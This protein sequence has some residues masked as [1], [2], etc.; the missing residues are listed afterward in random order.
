MNIT[1]DR[2]ILKYHSNS[3]FDTSSQF[4]FE[5]DKRPKTL[6]FDNGNYWINEA[7]PRKAN[8][9]KCDSLYLRK[10]YDF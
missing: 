4:M 6:H 3:Y 1:K 2:H 5:G 8:T 9:V 10:G 7:M